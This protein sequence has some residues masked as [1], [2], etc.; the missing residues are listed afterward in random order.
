MAAS[1][2]PPRPV[3]HL[4]FD[5]DGLLL[6]GYCAPAARESRAAAA[7][8][9]LSAAAAAAAAGPRP[10]PSG[11]RRGPRPAGRARGSASAPPGA[12][13][14]VAAPRVGTECV[15]GRGARG[16]GARGT[17]LRT[18]G[19]PRSRGPASVSPRVPWGAR[20]SP[21]APSAARR[22]GPPGMLLQAGAAPPRSSAACA[23]APCPPGAA[24]GDLQ[25]RV[26]CAAA[27]LG[28][29]RARS[30]HAPVRPGAPSPPA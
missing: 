11:G 5:L 3:T 8:E 15:W 13:L 18:D 29:S 20:P 14:P 2:P 28:R 12:P 6:G 25:L 4:L 7:E 9:G 26:T 16:G 17:P 24:R 22:A 27:G 30:P 10:G 19:R 1:V 23:R 21:A